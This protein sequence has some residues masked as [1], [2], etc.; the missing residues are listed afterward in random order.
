MAKK[1]SSCFN[2]T[3]NRKLIDSSCN[4]CGNY[5]YIEKAL[6]SLENTQMIN[7]FKK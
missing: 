5:E 1:Y 2:C 3:N 4:N 6:Q 7:F